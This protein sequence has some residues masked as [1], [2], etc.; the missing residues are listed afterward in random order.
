MQAIQDMWKKI[1]VNVEL[2]SQEWKV[3]QTT[4][5]HKQYEIARG[6]WTADYVDPMTFL[7]MFTSNSAQNNVDIIIQNMIS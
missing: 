7:D 4:R 1:G 3:F 2:Q 5:T 6:G